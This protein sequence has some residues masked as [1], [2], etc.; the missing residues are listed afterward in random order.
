MLRGGAILFGLEILWI[1]FFIITCSY[2]FSATTALGF[3]GSDDVRSDIFATRTHIG[4]LAIITSL[5]YRGAA[6]QQWWMLALILFILSNDVFNLIELAVYSRISQS[7]SLKIL[8]VIMSGL[9]TLISLLT[10]IWFIWEKIQFSEEKR[11]VERK[12]TSFF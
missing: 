10:G 12:R 7:T 1:I 8:A 3:V 6:R 9:S 4:I 11:M 5:Y 2:A